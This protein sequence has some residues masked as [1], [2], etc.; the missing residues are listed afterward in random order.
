[1]LNAVACIRRKKEREISEH[2]I[3]VGILAE[4]LM[5]GCIKDVNA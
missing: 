4:I 1:M 5:T 2:N 3:P